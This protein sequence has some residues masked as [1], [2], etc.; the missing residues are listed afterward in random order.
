[1]NDIDAIVIGA[2]AAGLATAARLVEAGQRVLVLEARDRIGGRVWTRTEPGLPA[3]LELGAEFIHGASPATFALLA[4]AGR[5]AMDTPGVHWRERNGRLA[6]GDDDFDGLGALMKGTSRLRR[7]VSF[8]EFLA[9]ARAPE[10][11]KSVARMM[12]Q[13][14]DAADPA[15]VSV[16]SIAAEWSGDAGTEAPQFR[17]IGGYGPLLDA[18][19]AALT[20]ERA[21]LR[22]GAVVRGVRWRR[23]RVDV[24]ADT[25]AGPLQVRARRAIVTLPLGVLQACDGEPGHVAFD[26]PLTAKSD[27]LAGLAPGPVLKLVLRFRTA[28]W[29]EFDRGRYRNVSFWHFPGAPFPTYWNA[30]PVRA[31]L[32]TA[33]AGGPRTAE[34]GTRDLAT[35][36]D[37][38]LAPLER[39]M[40]DRRWRDELVGSWVHDWQRDVFA[41]GAY[42][43]VCVNGAHARRSLARPLAGTLFFAGEASDVDGESGTV[44][45]ALQ[46]GERAAR[47]VLSA[48]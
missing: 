40:P 9:R 36:V 25:P 35:L 17:P 48:R 5:A 33:W 34:L 6:P 10:R 18:L 47:Q 7:D 21:Q 27:A 45:G 38:A 43:Y 15:R 14:F 46:S 11:V 12:V 24:A 30:L 13:G 28:F 26:P 44:A 31:P 29:D 1:M 42:S 20:P 37:R 19:A 3:P 2:G 22:L 32:V 23:G 4:R 39:A 41:R 8:D 16:Q